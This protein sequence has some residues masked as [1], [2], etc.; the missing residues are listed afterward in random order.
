[1][2]VFVSVVTDELS[3][4]NDNLLHAW[5]L[6]VHFWKP[7]DESLIL[8]G[9]Y[10]LPYFIEQSQ[11]YILLSWFEF[12]SEWVLHETDTVLNDKFGEDKINGMLRVILKNFHYFFILWMQLLL[13]RG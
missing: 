9:V 1:M 5:V 8:L 11:K 7:F 3:H 10:V 2:G 4:E 6:S 13:D 12:L